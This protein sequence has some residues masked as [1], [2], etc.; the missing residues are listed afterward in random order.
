MRSGLHYKNA[1]ERIFYL[2]DGVKSFVRKE[3]M[4]EQI[5]DLKRALEDFL[6]SDGSKVDLMITHYWD[7]A[8][9]GIAYL[10]DQRVKIPHIWVPHSLGVYKKRNVSPESWHHLR[11]DERITTEKQI[12]KQ[13]DGIGATSGMIREM[14]AD[15]YDYHGEVYWL[16]P[17]ID[18]S[19]FYPREVDQNDQVWEFLG[20]QI[21]LPAGQVR[22]RRI[23]TEVSRTVVNKRK[24]ILIKAYAGLK[25]DFPETLLVVSIDNREKELAEEL[26]GL[27]EDLGLI[28]EVVPVGSIWD[29][30]PTLYA[31]TDIFCTPSDVE[32]FGM[33]PQ[34]AAAT[35]V[36]IVSSDGVP[37]AT[38]Y[39][40]G[41]EI[42][43]RVLPEHPARSINIGEGAIIVPRGDIPGFTFAL[44]TLLSDDNSRHEMG[45]KAYRI[46]IPDFTWEQVTKKFL[47]AVGVSA[48]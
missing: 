28:G 47:N 12:V 1:S 30:L 3:N 40:L 18:T 8:L 17:C 29:L 11:V 35:K 19:H 6:V 38:E 10:E 45:E 42:A 34:E 7:A 16:P 21:D 27:I 4:G 5:P 24:D 44:R 9:L 2:Q 41:T 26:F 48:N 46:T 31:I 20:S 13:V 39:L 15:D 37:F 43:V 14:L 23:I 33:T 36:P 25:A 32:G 22:D